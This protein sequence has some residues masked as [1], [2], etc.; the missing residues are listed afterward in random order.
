[1]GEGACARER[2]ETEKGRERQRERDERETVRSES[3]A[4]KKR[5]DGTHKF[6][7]RNVKLM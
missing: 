2:R 3:V 5:K 1:M 6:H 7:S 4:L